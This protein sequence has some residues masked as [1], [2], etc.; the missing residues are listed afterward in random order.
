MFH[1]L[2]F[3][4]MPSNLNTSVVSVAEFIIRGIFVRIRP[5]RGVRAGTGVPRDD[6]GSSR[7]PSSVVLVVGSCVESL[8]HPFMVETYIERRVRIIRSPRASWS[9][10]PVV[11][12]SITKLSG[13]GNGHQE[14][15][16][17]RCIHHRHRHHTAS[18][19]TLT[20]ISGARPEAYTRFS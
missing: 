13:L 10:S 11:C 9:N 17:K 20:C 8:L 16:T 12:P 19:P 6:G 2:K 3:E 14:W 7:R 4:S 5:Y 1:G 15:Y 18:R